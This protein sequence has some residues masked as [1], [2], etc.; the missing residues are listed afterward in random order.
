MRTL[1][2]S[3]VRVAFFFLTW[4]RQQ[5]D[6]L[7]ILSAVTQLSDTITYKRE[8]TFNINFPQSCGCRKRTPFWPIGFENSSGCVSH[9]MICISRVTKNRFQNPIARLQLPCTLPACLRHL[10]CVFHILAV[11]HTHAHKT[12]ETGHRTNLFERSSWKRGVSRDDM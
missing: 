12:H 9:S 8:G 11:T 10:S 2:F 5:T 4:L 7:L 6:L 3:Y 1:V